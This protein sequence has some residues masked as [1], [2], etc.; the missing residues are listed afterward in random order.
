MPT[1]KKGTSFNS[2]LHK[3]V[4]VRVCVCSN[5]LD[6]EKKNHFKIKM[7]EMAVLKRKI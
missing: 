1:V 5:F 3:V 7:D 6:F 4:L 2:Y